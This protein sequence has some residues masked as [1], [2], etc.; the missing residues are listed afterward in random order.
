MKVLQSFGYGKYS[1]E[2]VVWQRSSTPEQRN[3]AN[4][5]AFEM[6]EDPANELF[7]GVAE[8]DFR[9]E[10]NES[11]EKNSE[12]VAEAAET[13]AD[14]KGRI[15]SKKQA[16][17]HYISKIE[18]KASGDGVTINISKKDHENNKQVDVFDGKNTTS[19]TVSGIRY[20]YLFS[21]HN[22]ENTPR[23][24]TQSEFMA[25]R[26]YDEF[27]ETLGHLNQDM[28]DLNSQLKGNNAPTNDRMKGLYAAVGQEMDGE[29][30]MAQ[31]KTA[32]G[33]TSFVKVGD[34][35][36]LNNF[37]EYVMEGVND[38][39]EEKQEGDLI[40][41]NNENIGGGKYIAPS[42]EKTVKV[43]DNDM[44]YTVEYPVRQSYKYHVNGD[45]Y[46][47]ELN[48]MVKVGPDYKNTFDG[49]STT[50]YQLVKQ[51]E[52]TEVGD[53]GQ[54]IATYQTFKK[55]N[56]SDKPSYDAYMQAE[57]KELGSGKIPEYYVDIDGINTPVPN[58]EFD[59]GYLDRSG[60]FVP[61]DGIA[62]EILRHIEYAE[63]NLT[64]KQRLEELKD[65]EDDKEYADTKKERKEWNK[66][67]KTLIKEAREAE[68]AERNARKEL[69]QEDKERPATEAV[70]E[71]VDKM[72]Q[73]AEDIAKY[74]K[75]SLGADIVKE[76]TVAVQGSTRTRIVKET[77]LIT[78]GGFEWNNIKAGIPEVSHIP[79]VSDGNFIINIG[80]ALRYE[81]ANGDRIDDILLDSYSNRYPDPIKALQKFLVDN[82][83]YPEDNNDSQVDG[84]YGPATQEALKRYMIHEEIKKMN[85]NK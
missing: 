1:V 64:V 51:Y 33:Q 65:H 46:K 43:N 68:K 85:K 56:F 74:A 35:N 81:N 40:D 55:I 79:S 19:Y 58:V 8:L 29:P 45:D 22:L 73:T 10:K 67:N 39:V 60:G 25:S 48:N 30:Y 23:S 4:E 6:I 16:I 82:N 15:E 54:E 13:K 37:D 44:P 36:T 38:A 72:P 53:Y 50:P 77:K 18:K 11:I 14:L 71:R 12:R 49:T 69:K 7:K 41:L 76:K 3:S 47:L 27:A 80:K 20:K 21:K 70:V 2:R 34:R 61:A 32:S 75:E 24:L 26:E 42:V 17:K 63:K 57:S 52:L 78:E 5:R 31:F 62:D 83:T 84:E 66:T 9:K 28:D 59:S